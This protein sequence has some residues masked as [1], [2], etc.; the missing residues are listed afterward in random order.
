[1]LRYGGAVAGNPPIPEL[2]SN[3]RG[4]ALLTYKIFWKK[5][6]SRTTSSRLPEWF[7]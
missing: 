6:N 5:L 2:C 3:Y 1:M 7:Y 4:I